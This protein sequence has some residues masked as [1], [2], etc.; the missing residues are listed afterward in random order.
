[1]SNITITGLSVETKTHVEWM[2]LNP[3]LPPT[4]AA[5][6]LDTKELRIGNG[7]STWS[8]LPVNSMYGTTPQHA[9]IHSQNG[10]DPITPMSIGAAAAN[11]IHDLSSINAAAVNHTHTLAELTGGDKIGSTLLKDVVSLTIFDQNG[12]AVKTLYGAGS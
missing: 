5:F 10:R 6:S 2:A 3:I 4:K 12:V 11:H 9:E 1:M 8:D 7:I